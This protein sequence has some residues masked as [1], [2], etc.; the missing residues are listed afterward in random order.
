MNLFYSIEPNIVLHAALLAAGLAT[1]AG[2]LLL[3]SCPLC[4]W[5]EWIAERGEDAEGKD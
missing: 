3:R 2:V 4:G 1:F 5:L